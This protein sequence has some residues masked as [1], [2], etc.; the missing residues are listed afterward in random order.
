MY[1]LIYDKEKGIHYRRWVPPD[2]RVVMVLVHGLGAHSERWRCMAEFMFSRGVASY[3]LELKGFGEANGIE[4]HV[5]SLDVY[6]DEISALS[7]LASL[8]NP[9]KK[10]FI[11]GESLGGLI[12][13]LAESKRPGGH[14]GLICISPAF[15]SRMTLKAREYALLVLAIIFAPRK[16]FKL[17]FD[18]SMCTRDEV[19]RKNIEAD[20]REHRT[21]TA[22]L[23]W[24]IL[25]AQVLASFAARRIGEPLL[26]LQAGEDKLVDPSSTRQVFAMIGATD[27]KFIEYPGMYHSLTID[28]GREQVFKDIF[29]W[30]EGRI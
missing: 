17:P 27:K 11:A 2:P 30:V 10:V 16:Y 28:Y 14:S 4:G 13:L 6:F 8:E 25:C 3:A 18:S 22:R 9:G 20:H 12:A 24:E 7:G 29:E 5:D 26:F 23:L 1:S 21:A 19:M 15:K